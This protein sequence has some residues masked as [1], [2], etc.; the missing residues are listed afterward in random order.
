MEAWRWSWMKSWRL[1]GERFGSSSNVSYIFPGGSHFSS[2]FWGWG[3]YKLRMCWSKPWGGVT[4]PWKIP[5]MVLDRYPNRSLNPRSLPF[6]RFI[7]WPPCIRDSFLKV[8][9]N[10]KIYNGSPAQRTKIHQMSKCSTSTS[11]M[12]HEILV[13]YWRDTYDGLQSS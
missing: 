11:D 4:K 9:G 2:G 12:H 5:I 10:L 8:W 1:C 13:D 6:F 3:F 7:R